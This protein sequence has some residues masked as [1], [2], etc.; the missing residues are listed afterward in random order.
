MLGRILRIGPIE[1]IANF[2][3]VDILNIIQQGLLLLIRETI[4]KVEQV[5]LA[6]FGQ[7][8]ANMVFLDHFQ[9]LYLKRRNVNIDE[10]CIEKKYN[11]KNDSHVEQEVNLR[12]K[13]QMRSR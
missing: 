11:N 4:E 1:G 5:L 3:Q 12:A 9:G 13:I 2:G 7:V 8:E 6:I 10:N